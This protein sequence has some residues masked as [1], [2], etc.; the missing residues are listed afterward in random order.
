MTPTQARPW[1]YDPLRLFLQWDAVARRMSY[2]HPAPPWQQDHGARDTFMGHTLAGAQEMCRLENIALQRRGT[3][4][5]A[6]HE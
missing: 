4:Q 3:R 1:Q 2:R 5:G 6:W